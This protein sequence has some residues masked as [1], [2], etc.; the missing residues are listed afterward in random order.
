M[1]YKLFT[2]FVFISTTAFAQTG[3]YKSEYDRLEKA[4]EAATR[5]AL[6]PIQKRHVADLQQLIRKASQAGDLET[7][8]KAK[9]A[10][11]RLSGNTSQVSKAPPQTPLSPQPAS[12]TKL[13]AN[14][15]RDIEKQVIGTLWIDTTNSH[16]FI[17][18]RKGG[19][20][21]R[22]QDSTTKRKANFQWLVRED[23]MIAMQNTDRYFRFAFPDAAEW[24]IPHGTEQEIIRLKLVPN[25]T[26]P[27]K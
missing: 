9:E 1:P 12:A 20:L 16:Q 21:T 8:V 10:A 7:A 27:D 17:Y 6:D 2:I 19:S 15:R 13:S 18:F 14:Q 24:I 22:V 25:G 26:D 5:Q 3:A 23:G 4:F 11:D